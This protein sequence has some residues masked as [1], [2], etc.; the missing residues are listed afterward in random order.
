[1]VLGSINKEVLLREALS[2]H[3]DFGT[4]TIGVRGKS[5]SFNGVDIPYFTAAVTAMSAS[6]RV[7]LLKYASSLFS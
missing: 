3:D 2:G 5:C 1:M 7:D 4:F 6:I